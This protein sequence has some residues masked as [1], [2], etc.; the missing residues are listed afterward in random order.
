MARRPCVCASPQPKQQADRR[1]YCQVCG[2]RVKG[3]RQGPPVRSKGQQAYVRMLA[4][5][6]VAVARAVKQAKRDAGPSRSW[7][8]DPD[9]FYAQAR[10]EAPRLRSQGRSVLGDGK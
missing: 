10:L 4:R 5:D 9:Q 7:W 2:R 8:L 6:S 3:P 1:F